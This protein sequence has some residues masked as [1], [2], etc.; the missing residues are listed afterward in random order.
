MLASAKARQL[1]DRTTRA[2]MHDLLDE[3]MQEEQDSIFKE[4]QL[5]EEARQKA[6]EEAET[7][8]QQQLIMEAQQKAK[9]EE[10]ERLLKEQ[11]EARQKLLQEEEAKLAEQKRLTAELKMQKER[12]RLEREALEKQ[13]EYEKQ[14]EAAIEKEFRERLS[15]EDSDKSFNEENLGKL[16]ERQIKGALIKKNYLQEKLKRVTNAFK[17]VQSTGTKV[18]ADTLQRYEQVRKK[19][20]KQLSICVK[21]LQAQRVKTPEESKPIS[22]VKTEEDQEVPSHSPIQKKHVS[23]MGEDTVS[24]IL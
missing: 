22:P 24:Y 6:L 15:S 10:E 3:I 7:L 2:I 14:R 23:P 11:E 8:K 13:L 19:V 5:A 18:D 9:Q 4:L 12:E 20:A 21:F 17:Y 1:E 16:T